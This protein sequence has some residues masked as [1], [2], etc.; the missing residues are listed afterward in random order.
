MATTLGLRHPLYIITNFDDLH[1]SPEI[2]IVAS[3][4]LLRFLP[5]TKTLSAILRSSPKTSIEG[6]IEILPPN[7]YRQFYHGSLKVASNW[8]PLVLEVELWSHSDHR[9]DILIGVEKETVYGKPGVSQ[10]TSFGC[11]LT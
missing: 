11:N 3:P 6:R 5:D 8:F 7:Y 9:E 10:D 2:T 1:S 4:N